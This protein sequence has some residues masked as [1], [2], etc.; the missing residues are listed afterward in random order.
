MASVGFECGFRFGEKIFSHR[1][2]HNHVARC[3]CLLP[4]RIVLQEKTHRSECGVGVARKVMK[5]AEVIEIVAGEWRARREYS[6]VSES[7]DPF[8]LFSFALRALDR[9]AAF[10]C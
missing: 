2:K 6:G 3:L 4:V 7:P 10:A 8:A 9:M 1:V 5:H